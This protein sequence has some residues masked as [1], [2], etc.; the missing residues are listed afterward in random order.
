MLGDSPPPIIFGDTDQID[1]FNLMD[2]GIKE[3]VL[4][5]Y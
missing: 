4:G 1:P 3:N 2:I 5:I